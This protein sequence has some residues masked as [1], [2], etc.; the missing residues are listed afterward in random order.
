MATIV[1]DSIEIA[2]GHLRWHNGIFRLT[3]GLSPWQT[4]CLSPGRFDIQGWDMSL[5]ITGQH[6]SGTPQRRLAR[7]D[8]TGVTVY[9]I[10]LALADEASSNLAT[11]SE[12][13]P[14]EK[15]TDPE[16]VR[17]RTDLEADGVLI[18]DGISR[19]FARVDRDGLRIF[20]PQ[21]RALVFGGPD[22][23]RIQRRSD[24]DPNLWQFLTITSDYLVI[25]LQR[26][27]ELQ[28][29]QCRFGHDGVVRIPHAAPTPEPF[30]LPLGR[31]VRAAT[32]I[33]EA[34]LVVVA[35]TSVFNR[36]SFVNSYDA[37]RSEIASE[38]IFFFH[39]SGV[40]QT[41]WIRWDGVYF[42]DANGLVI[43]KLTA[44]GLEPRTVRDSR[45][46]ESL[47]QRPVL[48]HSSGGDYANRSAKSQWSTNPP[49]GVAGGSAAHAR[50]PG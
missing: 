32:A 23:W 3:F 48:R 28:Q 29:M 25:G 7:L 37:G 40:C 12:P 13:K 34:D 14:I 31:P 39:Y 11:D 49:A 9:P 27:G 38:G 42:F 36:D 21:G 35:N 20:D 19:V 22:Y 1:A 18:S 43:R 8:Y 17:A 44:N 24:S 47:V 26:D 6:P 30:K 15:H 45:V 33:L 2:G 4:C 46:E 16:G 5:R 41:M 10:G 50:P